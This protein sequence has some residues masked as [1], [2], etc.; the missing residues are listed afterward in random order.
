MWSLHNFE[1]AV[2]SGQWQV[3]EL[4]PAPPAHTH[5]PTVAQSVT[6]APKPY[7]SRPNGFIPHMAACRSTFPVCTALD[8]LWKVWALPF[9][10]SLV[11]GSWARNAWP[12]KKHWCCQ[13]KFAREGGPK[14]Q[15]VNPCWVRITSCTAFKTKCTVSLGR[16]PLTLHIPSSLEC[17]QT[18]NLL[19]VWKLI[20]RQLIQLSSTG[21]IN[22]IYLP[23]ISNNS[24]LERMKQNMID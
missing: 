1:P 6:R 14:M 8:L 15:P 2:R 11:L 20:I 16:I 12:H 9:L 7:F 24:C 21:I 10:W 19:T 17:L 3:S 4:R 22:S 13:T 23:V 18:G 5:T